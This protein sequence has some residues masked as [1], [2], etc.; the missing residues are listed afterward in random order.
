[1]KPKQPA[2]GQFHVTGAHQFLDLRI[3]PAVEYYFEEGE[4]G[5]PATFSRT[6]EERRAGF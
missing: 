4:L 5:M 3:Q 2:S 6:A 1:L